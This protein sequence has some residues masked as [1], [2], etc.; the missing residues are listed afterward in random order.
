MTKLRLFLVPLLFLSSLMTVVAQP[1]GLQI[2]IDD[3]NQPIIHHTLEQGQTIYGLSKSYDADLDALIAQLPGN[4]VDDLKIGQDIV[5]P[6]LKNKICYQEKNCR[7]GLKIPVY[8][9]AQRQDNLF[10]IARIYFDTSVEQLKLI[11]NLKISLLADDQYIIIGWLPYTDE[12]QSYLSPKQIEVI[13]QV[14]PQEAE[15]GEEVKE[16]EPVNESVLLTLNEE[17]HEEVNSILE[18]MGSRNQ[19]NN[20]RIYADDELV[21]PTFNPENR[22]LISSG[23]TAYWNKNKSSK[24]GFYLLHKSL[25]VNTLIHITNPVTHQSVLAKVVG[26]IPDNIYSPEISVVVT[27]EVA[28]ALGAIDKKFYTK[29]TYPEMSY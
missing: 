29:I 10:R 11:N 4:Q 3:H 27:S 16:P 6:I 22:K 21:A 18:G 2:Y 14:T 7:D 28:Q 20:E 12:W 24:K 8:Y 26:K 9:K 17:K 19:L 5:V 23:A 25:P 1:S 15:I 13:A